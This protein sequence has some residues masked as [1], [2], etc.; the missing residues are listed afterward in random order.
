METHREHWQQSVQENP[1]KIRHIPSAYITQELCDLVVKYDP[2]LVEYVPDRFINL[3][4]FENVIDRGV[5]LFYIIGVFRNE[6]FT[7]KICRKL[8]EKNGNYL[9]Y[10][11]REIL[12]K[13]ICELALL[14][15]PDGQCVKDIP[16]KFM[17]LT[18]A[19]CVI[20]KS[21]GK[22]IQDIPKELLTRDLCEFAVVQKRG[23]LL[24]IPISKIDRSLCEL[25]VKTDSFA[26]EFV[27][28]E[29]VDEALC[30]L[31]L[32]TWNGRSIELVP[33]EYKTE[34]LCQRAFD[35][36]H[37]NIEFIPDRFK[38]PEMCCKSFSNKVTTLQVSHKWTLN[39]TF[40]CF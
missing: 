37:A 32:N 39:F 9:K 34:S 3:Q 26:L 8:L 40:E 11:P 31:A 27:P 10:I 33:N 2:H 6:H 14:K 22:Y 21:G 20:E 19:R 1:K 28:C 7:E 36:R 23:S 13:D 15:S 18:M 29:L 24:R 5:S 25:A 30:E 35:I 38:T 12:T 17:D 16:P 4:M